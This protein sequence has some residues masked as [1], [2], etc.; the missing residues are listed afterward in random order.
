MTWREEEGREVLPGTRSRGDIVASRCQT[1]WSFQFWETWS[2]HSHEH[3][4]LF[5]NR[6]QIYIN[7]KYKPITPL[8]SSSSPCPYRWWLGRAWCFSSLLRS[9]TSVSSSSSLIFSPSSNSIPFLCSCFSTTLPSCACRYDRLETRGQ[10]AWT[11]ALHGQQE[12]MFCSWM[13]HAL[14]MHIRNENIY[15]YIYICVYMYNEVTGQRSNGDIVIVMNDCGVLSGVVM[16]G[17]FILG[18][19]I[20]EVIVV[21]ND[22]APASPASPASPAYPASMR[23]CAALRLAWCISKPHEHI[24]ITTQ[25]C[26]P[27][28]TYTT[29]HPS[30]F[31]LLFEREW[32]YFEVT[33]IFQLSRRFISLVV[34]PASW[35]KSSL[36]SFYPYYR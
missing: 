7:W 21:F 11:E 35:W 18:G 3:S 9:E 25:V 36:L 19:V 17:G 26:Y 5:L 4:C 1:P 31:T 32:Y 10:A 23:R 14:Y 8:F 29:H 6:N 27:F 34:S 30:Y 16:R 12:V 22:H 28:T 24:E 2:L 33:I 13:V 20:I 15:I